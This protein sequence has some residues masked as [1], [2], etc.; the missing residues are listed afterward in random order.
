MARARFFPTPPATTS[1]VLSVTRADPGADNKRVPRWSQHR[2]EAE[3]QRVEA[4]GALLQL[5]EHA[6]GILDLIKAV[7]KN[8]V[9]Y[10]GGR[11][12]GANGFDALEWPD[13]SS[14]VTI[15]NVSCSLL[16]IGGSGSGAPAGVGA[17]VVRIPPG[18]FRTFALRGN[19]L[20]VFGFAGSAFDVTVW[21]RPR[22][23]ASGICGIA[24]GAVL[25]PAGTT[26]TQT[27]TLSGA[28]LQHIAA[29][30]GVSAVAGGT[31][32]VTLNG[33]TPSG[34][35]YPL[36]VGLAV[37]ATGVTPY[38]IG[39]GLTPSANAVADDLVPQVIQVV[40]TTAGSITYGVDLVA[41]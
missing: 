7:P 8:Y 30:L 37:G 15:A 21:A 19:G 33:I 34:L 25:I 28:N 11:I 40:A 35:V 6:G 3:A 10:S 9:R 16:T 18:T 38:R 27:V 12:I 13:V 14:A 22:V 26:T 17:G 23:P 41:G 4:A 2:Q 29:V 39:P 20:K 5:T 24:A 36:L 32:Q 31:V 1:T